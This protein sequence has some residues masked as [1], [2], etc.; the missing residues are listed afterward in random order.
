MASDLNNYKLDKF[1]DTLVEV[2]FIDSKI[3]GCGSSL[4]NA[5]MHDISVDST[6]H[7]VESIGFL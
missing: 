1:T 6:L 2:H 7:M 4:D 3:R 5:V